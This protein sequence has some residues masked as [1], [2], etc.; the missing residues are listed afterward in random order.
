M[1]GFSFPGQHRNVRRQ[2]QLAW[3]GRRMNLF[4]VS[5]VLSDGLTSTFLRDKQGGVRLL[6]A[7]RRFNPILMDGMPESIRRTLR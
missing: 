4:E 5:R 6:R 2:L 1:M 7:R 3:S